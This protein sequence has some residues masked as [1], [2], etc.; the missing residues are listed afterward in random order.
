MVIMKKHRTSRVGKRSNA[1]AISTEPKASKKTRV[2]TTEKSTVAK[3][4]KITAGERIH[5]G[6][7][8]RHDDD[9]HG[10]VEQIG[11]ERDGAHRAG[12]TGVGEAR[13]DEITADDRHD[14]WVERYRP[15]RLNDLILPRRLS[16]NFRR[17]IKS[18]RIPNLLLHG[19]PGLGKTTL[20]RL[21]AKSVA[22]DDV[23]FVN[24]SRDRGIDVLR[25]QIENFASAV[26]FSGNRKI[27]ILDEADSLT[28]EMT[29]ALRGTMEAYAANCGFVLTANDLD[30]I[31]AALRSRCAV[32]DLTPSPGEYREWYEAARA[33]IRQILQ[34]ERAE[35]DADSINDIVERHGVDLRGIL[36]ELQAMAA[37]S[38]TKPT[39]ALTNKVGEAVSIIPA[40]DHAAIALGDRDG[41]D[42]RIDRLPNNRSLVPTSD[43]SEGAAVLDG[44][45]AAIK[46]HVI[47]P[48]GA[49][50]TGAL[51]VVHAHAHDAAEFSPIL[52]AHSPLPE[53]GK[54]TLLRIL[55]ATTPQ[56]MPANNISK[57][58]LYRVVDTE[59]P[60][61][62]IDEADTFLVRNQEMRGILD[63]GQ[64][65]RMAYVV[66]ADGSFS[67][68]CPKVI[69]CIG[70]LP[71]TLRSR[72]LDIRL[73]RKQPHEKIERLNHGALEHLRQLGERAARWTAD[74][75]DQL[76][77]AD[78]SIPFG[79]RGRVADNWR[80]LLAIADEAGGRWPALTRALALEASVGQQADGTEGEML[81]GDIRKVFAERRTD[82]IETK[83]LIKALSKMVDRPWGNW[84]STAPI[85]DHQIA[86]LL[87]PF[88][89]GPTVIRIGARTARGYLG[90]DFE[91]AFARYL[92]PAVT[93]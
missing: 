59:R 19:P 65:R 66:R 51:F 63:S 22:D 38:V 40:M 89:I 2:I 56:P 69:A 6:S 45:T 18:G 68:W 64:C 47:T 10:V 35:Y 15:R 92:P 8:D 43:R 80:P 93:P 70:E 1:G 86:R 83:D 49:A 67:T 13:F 3:G 7:G 76:A 46:R 58:A 91:D 87:R 84:N 85:K 82:R 16:G 29:R 42:G 25:N 57:A 4:H 44:L 78:P 48:P 75:F 27:V 50:E 33:H 73:D 5:G 52:S 12:E 39:D 20:A 60:T 79:I 88:Q 24:A 11:N 26:S 23:F 36:N 53:C 62:L 81:L 30:R 32:F 61:L 37:P 9:G 74:H 55:E 41:D 34:R 71:G 72:S 17:L 77:S 54:T 28:D 21:M 90:R 31:P 14:Q